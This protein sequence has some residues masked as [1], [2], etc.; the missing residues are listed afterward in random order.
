[1][2]Y[3]RCWLS[4]LKGNFFKTV[5][6]LLLSVGSTTLLVKKQEVLGPLGLI[7]QDSGPRLSFVTTLDSNFQNLKNKMIVLPE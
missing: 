5:L 1:M 7:G 3:L 6:I 4:V 2:I